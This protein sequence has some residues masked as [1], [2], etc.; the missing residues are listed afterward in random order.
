MQPFLVC[1]AGEEKFLRPIEKL[2][3]RKDEEGQEKRE[4]RPSLLLIY[5]K[6]EKYDSGGNKTTVHKLQ[7]LIMNDDLWDIV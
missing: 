5:L 3:R 7:V 4:T 6:E 1:Y 2:Q